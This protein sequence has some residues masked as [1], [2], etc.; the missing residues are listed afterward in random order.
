MNKNT[1]LAILPVHKANTQD[2]LA[3]VNTTTNYQFSDRQ[4]DPCLI[5]DLSIPM[6][7]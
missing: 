4:F 2:Q 3:I 5:P 1:N 7:T 6:I